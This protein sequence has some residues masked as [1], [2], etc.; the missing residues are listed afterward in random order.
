VSK[1]ERLYTTAEIAT[2]FKVTQETVR[3]WIKQGKL[4]AIKPGGNHNR[5]THDALVEFTEHKYGV[6]K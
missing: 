1:N 6:D 5:I 2:L 3:N 4:K